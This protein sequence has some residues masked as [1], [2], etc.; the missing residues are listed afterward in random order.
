MHF[1]NGL[2]GFFLLLNLLPHS[3]KRLFGFTNNYKVIGNTNN[4]YYVCQQYHTAKPGQYYLHF[5][6]FSK[7]NQVAIIPSGIA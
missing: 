2:F 6:S 1:R 4:Q 7:K 5:Y 3:L